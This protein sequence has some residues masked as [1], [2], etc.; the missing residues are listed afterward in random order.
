MSQD[1]HSPTRVAVLDNEIGNGDRNLG[2]LDCG[3]PVFHN[4]AIEQ[5][6]GR[7]V[8]QKVI[9]ADATGHCSK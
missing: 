7:V 2:E 8:T 1:Y 9:G 4:R 5:F 6:S 3:R